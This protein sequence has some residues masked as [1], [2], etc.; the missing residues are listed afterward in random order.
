MRRIFCL[1]SDLRLERRGQNA[2][3]EAEQSEQRL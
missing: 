3:D 2:Q 1:K